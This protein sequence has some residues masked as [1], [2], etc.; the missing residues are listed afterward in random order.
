MPFALIVFFQIMDLGVTV[1]AGSD[2]VC[3]AGIDYLFGLEASILATGIGKSGLEK[4]AAAAATVVIGHIGR[5]ID[6][7]LFA[8]H[9]LDHIAQIFSHRV[10]EGLSDELAGILYGKG[11]LE[12]PVPV[13][14]H[15]QFSLPDPLCI[16]LDNAFDLEVV[17]DVEFFESGPDCKEFVAS[18][19]VEPDLAAQIIHRLCLYP[20]DMFPGCI[21]CK[22]HAVIFRGPPLGTVGPV[23]PDFI[24]NFP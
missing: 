23:S 11:Y 3:G 24:E 6:E 21:V 15:R 12:V 7:V 22:E 13:G 5:H 18:L 16:V 4:S 10:A 17:R 1:M 20:D 8:D 9:L 19:R 2:R 14:I